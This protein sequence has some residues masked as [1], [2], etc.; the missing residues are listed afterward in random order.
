MEEG[1]LGDREQGTH[2]SGG[3]WGG[4]F[5]GRCS[6]TTLGQKEEVSDGVRGSFGHAIQA[7]PSPGK[8]L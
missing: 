8:W 4:M 6:E 7:T 5:S 3:V 1:F 2:E